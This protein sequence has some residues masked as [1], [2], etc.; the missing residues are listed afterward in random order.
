MSGTVDTSPTVSTSNILGGLGS[1]LTGLA[2][3]APQIA[4]S[5]S[6]LTLPHGFAAWA[7]TVLGILALFVK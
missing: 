5:V 7:Q 2:L 4:A 6:N 3:A 1:T